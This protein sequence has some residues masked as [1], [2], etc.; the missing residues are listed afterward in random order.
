MLEEFQI[1]AKVI[2]HDSDVMWLGGRTAE[3]ARMA[4]S[5]RSEGRKPAILRKRRGIY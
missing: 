1:F 4:V 2:A 5:Q 3:S